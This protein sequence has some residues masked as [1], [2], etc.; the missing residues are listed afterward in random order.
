MKQLKTDYWHTAREINDKYRERVAKA[1]NIR[2]SQA[3]GKET[4]GIEKAAQVMDSLIGGACHDGQTFNASI[5]KSHIEAEERKREEIA[6]FYEPKEHDH[7]V[8]RIV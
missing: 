6:A 4:R 8:I 7:P 2:I 3:N 5:V 1:A